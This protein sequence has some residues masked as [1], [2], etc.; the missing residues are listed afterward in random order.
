M[1]DPESL[2]LIQPFLEDTLGHVTTKIKKLERTRYR[3]EEIVNQ[4][5]KVTMGMHY[6]TA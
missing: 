4:F 3:I 2:F 6:T 1:Q 5:R